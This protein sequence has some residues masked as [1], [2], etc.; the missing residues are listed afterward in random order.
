MTAQLGFDFGGDAAPLFSEA[1]F[2]TWNEPVFTVAE[3]HAIF[4]KAITG[5]ERIAGPARPIFREGIEAASAELTKMIEWQSRDD[6]QAFALWH[7]DFKPDIGQVL[8]FVA[9]CSKMIGSSFPGIEYKV[10]STARMLTAAMYVEN[11]GTLIVHQWAS[12]NI[13]IAYHP[14]R[15]H[16]FL[17]SYRDAIQRMEVPYTVWGRA[18]CADKLAMSGKKVASVPTFSVNGREYINDGTTSRGSYCE[19]KGWTFCAPG[20]WT[21]PTYTYE[22]Q[23]KAWDDGRAERGDRRG[24]IISVRGKLCVLNGLAEFYDNN[25]QFGTY[26]SDDE[27]SNDISDHEDAGEDEDDAADTL[28]DEL[29]CE[30]A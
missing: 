5:L 27:K 7:P 18:Y 30:P 13:G 28:I 22:T 10:R 3:Y 29:E 6:G 16:F 11:V 1:P 25:A 21:G 9:H 14:Y 17:E 26:I 15:D 2:G 4:A 20:D 24:L 8:D 23:C 19:C 12:D